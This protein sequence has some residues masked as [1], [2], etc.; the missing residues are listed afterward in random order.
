M[1]YVKREG[2]GW[3]RRALNTGSIFVCC[4]NIVVGC[5][6]KAVGKAK[7]GY[8][9]ARKTESEK[10]TELRAV[11]EKLRAAFTVLEEM[12]KV[13]DEE[14]GGVNTLFEEKKGLHEEV[15]KCS[16]LLFPS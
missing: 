4:L 7:D 1:F 12:G 8:G 3:K 6:P 9:A 16:K 10:K 5:H 15:K 2:E 11:Q 13:R 14:G